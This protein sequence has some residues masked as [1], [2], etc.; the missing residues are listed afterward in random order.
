MSI[1]FLGAG[2]SRPAGLP[3]GKGLSSEILR[4][5]KLRGHYDTT[6]KYDIEAY[7]DYYNATHD[8][9]RNE[10]EINFEEFMSYLDIEHY[11]WLMG[12]DTTSSQSVIRN[13]IA[14][15]LY[16]HESKMNKQGFS[17]YD[18]FVAQLK[19]GDWVFTFNYDTLLENAFQKQGVPYRLYPHKYKEVYDDSSG[20]I[21]TET[22]EVILLKMHGS[23]N[24]FDKS[25]YI[26]NQKKYIGLT[27]KPRHV[28]FDGRINPKSIHRLVDEPYFKDDRLYNVYVLE[29]LDTY[30][31]ESEFVFEEP[32]IVSP[33]YN[34]LVY[35]NHT[36]DFWSGFMK[37]GA[38]D[39]LSLEL[40]KRARLKR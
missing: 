31:E 2:F 27:R 38:L 1:F 37:S 13:L 17:L 18:K 34:K 19:P 24:W 10:V 30:F 40:V 36:K 22:E 8:E 26:K 20:Y 21:D 5:A 15:T 12:S 29:D 33:S 32:L 25:D 4:F 23:L 16:F 11:L 9:K 35:L 6:L 14:L 28:V 7:L 3:L 39:N